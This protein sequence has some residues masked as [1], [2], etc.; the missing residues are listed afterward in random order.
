M[1]SDYKYLDLEK[2]RESMAKRRLTETVDH[3]ATNHRSVIQLTHQL[4]PI[5]KNLLHLYICIYLG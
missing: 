4:E 1:K 3:S 2:S 5:K